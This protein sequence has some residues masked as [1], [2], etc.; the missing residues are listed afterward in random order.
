MELAVDT[1]SAL[2]QSDRKAGCKAAAS[3]GD[4]CCHRKT[5]LRRKG[6][7]RQLSFSRTLCGL[8]EVVT[9]TV[10]EI[11]LACCQFSLMAREL[12]KKNHSFVLSLQVC[13][14]K[15]SGEHKESLGGSF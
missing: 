14:D 2:G 4:R 1:L 15:G 6:Q 11:W 7:N 13:G 9:V 5:A 3:L 10:G 8:Y 12:A